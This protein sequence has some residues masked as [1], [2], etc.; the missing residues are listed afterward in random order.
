MSGYEC[1]IGS[2]LG[3]ELQPCITFSHT[4]VT[5]VHTFVYTVQANA[6]SPRKRILKWKGE[7]QRR[8]KI[9]L[10]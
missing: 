9:L 2:F 4:H 7:R 6:H 5:H 3:H 1:C 10:I 8:K